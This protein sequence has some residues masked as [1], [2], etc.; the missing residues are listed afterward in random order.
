[1]SSRTLLIGVGTEVA[2]NSPTTLDNATVVRVVNN[3]GGSATVSV[4][5]STSV[6]YAD[7]ATVTLPQDAVEFFQKNAQDT[8]SGSAATVL[9][10]KV[11]FT[12]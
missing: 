12:N 8:I 1:M 6:G 10:F 3:S 11:G 4:A 7:T 2:L 9:G 5:K